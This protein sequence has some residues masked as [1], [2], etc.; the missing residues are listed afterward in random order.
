MGADHAFV[1]IPFN[2]LGHIDAGKVIV[3]VAVRHPLGV[4]RIVQ[5]DVSQF[6]HR[7]LAAK[8]IRVGDKAGKDVN[9]KFI[10]KLF[11]RPIVRRQHLDKLLLIEHTIERRAIHR[12]AVQGGENAFFS[13]HKSS[14]I[15]KL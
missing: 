5:L 3:P 10:E 12:L 8:L 6:R 13:V 11:T 14:F 4:A 15:F 9:I 7:K 2:R 1:A